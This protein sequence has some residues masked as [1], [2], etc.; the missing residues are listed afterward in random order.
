MK[1]RRF[2]HFFLFLLIFPVFTAAVRP[3]SINRTDLVVRH[4]PSLQSVDFMSPFSVGNGGFAFTADVTGMQS[5]PEAYYANGMPIETLS[6]WAWHSMPNPE[7]FR[8]D[9]AFETVDTHGK[10]IGY[11]TVQSSPAGKWLRANPHRLPLGQMGFRFQKTDGTPV[12]LEDIRNID[13]KLNLW[14]GVLES[15]Y[16]VDGA[17]VRVTTVCHPRL[18]M[19]SVRVE[20]PL[21]SEN[22]IVL[23]I[24]FAYTYDLSVKNKPP[25]DWSRPDAHATHIVL[26]EPNRIHFS[27][28]VDSS[29]Y[30]VSVSWKHG[31]AL[32]VIEPHRFR[33]KPSPSDSAFEISVLFSPDLPGKP[34]PDFSATLKECKSFW[35]RFWESGG[36]IDLSG[37]SD[38]RAKELER[39]IV[40]S[41]YLTRIQSAGSIPPQESGLTHISWFGKHHT[42]M[43]WWHTAHFALWGR[44]E[45]L[46]N[47][48]SWFSKVLPATIQSTK[49][50]RRCNGAR[51]SKMVGPE[52]RE[53]PGGNPFIIW[54]QPHPIALA[55]LCYRSCPDRKT[56]LKYRE[57]V[58]HSAEY[59]SE[60]AYWDNSRKRY[61]LGPPVWL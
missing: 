29:S 19:V 13:Q 23:D 6:N 11:P 61:V 46:E 2:S 34:N 25:L 39:R 21:I 30:A 41:Q 43:A 36:A 3:R 57:I 32:E 1:K 55:E 51:W 18:D 56:L 17:S 40:L 53:S 31:A 16:T 26:R 44:V 5:F 8:L 4:N 7:Q 60:Y 42:E 22:R 14:T 47:S 10:K 45:N 49:S 33:I 27:R 35:R 24:G 28:N 38:P 59:M 12:R 9:D 52:G 54:N 37:S 15:A 48:L 50:E 58:F 20:S